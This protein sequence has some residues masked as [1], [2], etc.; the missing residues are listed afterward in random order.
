M[1]V[2]GN[3]IP[4]F[5]FTKAETQISSSL[6]GMLNA[7]TPLFTVILGFVWLK[8]KV[9]QSSECVIIG[10]TK[11]KGDRSQTFGAL[12]IAERAGEELL[13]EKVA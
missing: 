2:C 3:L 11:G 9:R 12:H 7:L 13:G 8:I 6:T 4:A 5:L 1:G 10:Y